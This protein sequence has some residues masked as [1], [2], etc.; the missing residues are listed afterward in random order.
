MKY[1]SPSDFEPLPTN[2]ALQTLKRNSSPTPTSSRP[3]STFQHHAT[4]SDDTQ[5][6]PHIGYISTRYE[7]IILS[8]A[9]HLRTL[10]PIGGL[11]SVEK[12]IWWMLQG[13]KPT[14]PSYKRRRKIFYT[15]QS[16]AFRHSK[17]LVYW[18][19]RTPVLLLLLGSVSFC[20][21]A[22][23][24][25]SKRNLPSLLGGYFLTSHSSQ[26]HL[27]V[28]RKKPS[29]SLEKRWWKQLQNQATHLMYVNLISMSALFHVYVN[30]T[31]CNCHIYKLRF[32]ADIHRKPK[33]KNSYHSQQGHRKGT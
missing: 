32:H 24:N 1:I 30:L 9:M 28:E 25:S 12:Q 31:E 3:T 18:T 11:D 33:G 19:V 7:T 17:L 5:Q 23:Q 22:K 29:A 16:L 20:A 14:T 6:L 15:L 4:E 2:W 8:T 13:L 10:F 26:Q 21:E 27:R